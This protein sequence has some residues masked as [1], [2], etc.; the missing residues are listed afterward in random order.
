MT[1]VIQSSFMGDFKLADNIC[2][3]LNVI[4]TLRAYRESGNP[5]QRR[6]LQKPL[7][8]LNVAIVEALLYDLHK[9]VKWF[10]REGVAGIPANIAA[11]IRGKQIDKLETLIASAKKHDLFDEDGSD[12]YAAL[13][14]LRRIRNRLHI[15]NEKA[16]LESDDLQAFS[17]DRL[18]LSERGVE[19]VMMTIAAKYPRSGH[20]YTQAFELPWPTYF[21]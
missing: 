2:H 19:F 6:Y 13:D 20:T 1:V 9:R 7:I 14:E 21:P 3:N 10:T 11:Y 18:T 15:Q 8:I 12:F 5:A 4:R 17:E 16:D